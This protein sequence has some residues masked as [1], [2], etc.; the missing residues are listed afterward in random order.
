MSLW[1]RLVLF[2]RPKSEAKAYELEWELV[3]FEF[4][5]NWFA[6]LGVE[7]MTIPGIRSHERIVRD[8]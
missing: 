7:D 4:E 8:D 2:F 5:V 1:K 3:P 6:P